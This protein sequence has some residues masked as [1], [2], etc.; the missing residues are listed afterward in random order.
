MGGVAKTVAAGVATAAVLKFGKDC[1][2]A[3]GDADAA[4]DKVASVFGDSAGEIEKFSKNTADSMGLSSS[5]FQAMAAQSGA[6]MQSVGINADDAAKRTE[7]MSGALLILLPSMGAM[8]PKLW[9]RL[10]KP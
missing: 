5:Q 4:M 7:N 3:A 6:L 10:I 1:L 8:H 9:M 2:D